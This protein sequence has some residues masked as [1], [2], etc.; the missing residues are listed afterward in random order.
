MTPRAKGALF[1][2]AF[3]AMALVGLGVRHEVDRRASSTS[4]STST[5]ARLPPGANYES[6]LAEVKKKRK[7]AE[8]MADASP[9]S[10]SRRA[11]V[12]SLQ[13]GYAQLSGDYEGYY[14]ADR[15][16]AE[17]FEAARAGV[18]DEN[19]GPLLL[20][21]QLSYELH[22]LQPALDALRAP[23]K[24]A[25]FFHDDK[26]MSEILSLRGA[27]TFALGRYQ[28]GI[29]MLRR[30]IELDPSPG[31]E[32]RLAIA[33]AKVG[34]Y[35]EATRIFDETEP[36]A[37]SPRGHAWIEMQRGLM[38]RDLGRREDA[39]R[40]FEKACA[41]FP[42]YWQ[43]EEHLAEL[44]A[45]DGRR[46]RATASYRA[47]VTKT[48]DPEFM[49]ALA[50]LVADR[51]PEEARRLVERSNAIYEERLRK[52]PEASYGHAL[53]HY[54]RMVPDPTRA[55]AIAE[56]NRDLRPN[57]EART[58]LAQAYLRAGRA[59]EASEEMRKVL[60]SEWK[61]AESF[62]TA[63]IALR[64][65]GDEEGAQRAEHEALALNPYAM[66]EIEWLAR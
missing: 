32:Q 41:L 35:E 64:R 24:Q 45:D 50:R 2:I 5:T 59:R 47:L 8:I 66:Q 51:E 38:A 29:A 34:G 21:A 56:K 10:W 48:G 30:S 11:A 57:G 40:H 13:M 54:L 44:D 55:V 23:E 1:A 27:I 43:A 37:G 46:D 6:A 19:V 31:H 12:A 7:V 53:E 16:L 58:R 49:D 14:A 65:V 20:K 63:A 22:R 62:A 42:G 25:E 17:A 60:A 39:R 15:S 18:D 28:E 4:T 9:G 52:L 3:T 36:K 26:Q 33:L 61:H